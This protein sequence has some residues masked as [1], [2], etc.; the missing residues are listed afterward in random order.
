MAQ[1]APASTAYRGAR[2]YAV[3]RDRT[4]RQAAAAR[5]PMV[6]RIASL[7]FHHPAA[8]AV[9]MLQRAPRPNNTTSTVWMRMSMSSSRLWFFT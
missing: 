6:G 7:D 2:R 8:S 1:L 3:K 9:E 4:G 5:D